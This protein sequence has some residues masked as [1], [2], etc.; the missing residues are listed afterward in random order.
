MN[1]LK[2]I[3]FGRHPSAAKIILVKAGM[4]ALHFVAF[5]KS[6][7]ET[8]RRRCVSGPDSCAIQGSVV[9]MNARMSFR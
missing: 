8:R 7:I 5:K 3:R 9:R 2:S 1:A 6:W 4:G